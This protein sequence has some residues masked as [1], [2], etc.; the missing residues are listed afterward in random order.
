MHELATE[1]IQKRNEEVIDASIYENQ[2]KI[3]PDG[4]ELMTYFPITDFL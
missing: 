3:N 1:L 4:C 2:K